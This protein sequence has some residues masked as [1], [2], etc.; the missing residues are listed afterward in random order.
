MSTYDI[1]QSIKK[2]N[3]ICASVILAVAVALTIDV[4]TIIDVTMD[5]I[6]AARLLKKALQLASR[7]AVKKAAGAADAGAAVIVIAIVVNR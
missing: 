4:A 3:K 6:V 1:V 5:G 7:K 2:E